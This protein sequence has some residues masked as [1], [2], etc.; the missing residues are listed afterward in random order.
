MGI[1][2]VSGVLDSLAHPQENGTST[3][4]STPS[5]S[6]TLD[7]SADSVPNKFI[8]CVQ[9]EESVRKLRKLWKEQT[10]L[11]VLAGENVAAV[12]QADV[13]LLGSAGLSLSFWIVSI[14]LCHADANRR[15]PKLS[16]LRK[17]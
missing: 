16:L 7:A 5:S 13:I 10:G 14:F 12:S 4:E 9:R 8:A 15:W 17:A 6:M 2:I 11:E 1:A 3:K